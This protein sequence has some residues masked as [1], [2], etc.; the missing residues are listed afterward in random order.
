MYFQKIL[1]KLT[2][3]QMSFSHQEQVHTTRGFA[4]FGNRPDNQG[5]TSRHIPSDKNPNI[6]SPDNFRY[7]FFTLIKSYLSSI[8]G[9]LKY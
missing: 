9:A 5:L 8:K 4:T 2:V 7:Q 3:R 6:I 1:Q